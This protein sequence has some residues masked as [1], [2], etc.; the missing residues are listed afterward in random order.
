MCNQIQN[1]TW[2]IHVSSP[3]GSCGKGLGFSGFCI[4]DPS[5]WSCDHDHLVSIP[6]SPSTYYDGMW[7]PRHHH[8]P[9]VTS[10]WVFT[11]IHY[12]ITMG[13][14]SDSLWHH[15]GYLPWFHCDVTMGIYS[16][17]LW[18]H[19]VYLLWF[20]V[21]SQWVFTL[22]SSLWYHAHFMNGT[23]IWNILLATLDF[24]MHVS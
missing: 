18:H 21:T 2:Y 20:I 13:I 17:S 11:L 16:D 1:L 14:Y 5:C 12:D 10:Q 22:I 9:I 4:K 19:N 7:L 6:M 23:V 24:L 8:L 15:N 3:P